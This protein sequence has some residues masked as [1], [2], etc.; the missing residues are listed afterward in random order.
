MEKKDFIVWASR[1]QASYVPSETVKQLIAHVELVAIVGP[2]GAGKSTVIEKLG[3]PK[4]MS[5]V[6]RD[7]RPGEKDNE[8]YHFRNDYLKMADDI[9]Q[10]HYV[11]FLISNGGEFY[12]TRD[13]EYPPNGRCVMAVYATTVPHFRELGF[14]KVTPIYIM[15]PSY[16]EWMR[17]IGGVRTKDLLT[18]ISEAKASLLTALGDSEYQFV[19]NDN[20]ELALKDVESILSGQETDMRRRN[21]AR[22][23]ADL[24]L[25]HIGDVDE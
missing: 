2:T 23:T 13:S 12:G 16:V 4:V 3:Y 20:L 25:E 10:Q 8:S 1:L 24:L 5:D 6:T 22:E 21:L 7:K 15:P 19:L 18:R 9:K 17:R 14:K 11:Q